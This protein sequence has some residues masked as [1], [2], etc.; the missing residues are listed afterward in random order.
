M[1]SNL[2]KYG[3]KELPEKLKIVDSR[4]EILGKYKNTFCR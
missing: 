1:D 3:K 4:E 2:D